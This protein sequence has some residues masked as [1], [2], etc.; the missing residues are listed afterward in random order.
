MYASK[1]MHAA[2]TALGVILA[3]ALHS[4]FNVLILN[5]SPAQMMTTFFLVWMCVI[6]FLA[7]LEWV[8]R[9]RPRTARV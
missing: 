4:C 1:R 7:I 6:A 8:K 9:I 2:Y 5:A 3:A